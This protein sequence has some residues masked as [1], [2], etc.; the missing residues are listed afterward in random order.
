MSFVILSLLEYDSPFQL[1]ITAGLIPAAA[2]SF[3]NAS[4]GGSTWLLTTGE[5]ELDPRLRH[6]GSDAFGGKFSS[7]CLIRQVDAR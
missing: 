2:P 6:S 4:I 5:P 1:S 7:L 3:P